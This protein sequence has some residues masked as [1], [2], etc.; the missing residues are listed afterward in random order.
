MYWFIFRLS[1]SIKGLG[2][3]MAHRRPGGKPGRLKWLAVPVI[4]L[5][6]AMNGMARKLPM[7]PLKGAKGNPALREYAETMLAMRR[8]P[9]KDTRAEES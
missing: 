7:P 5:G 1:V 2:E 8:Q 3:R 6:L 4:R 9:Q